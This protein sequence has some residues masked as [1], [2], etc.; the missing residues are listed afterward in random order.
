MSLW[1]TA[2]IFAQSVDTLFFQYILG[3]DCN[4]Y[5]ENQSAG[6]Y[7]GYYIIVAIYSVIVI[8]LSLKDL[9]ETASMQAVLTGYRFAAFFAMGATCLVASVYPNYFDSPDGKH[10]AAWSPFRSARASEIPTVE[11]SQFD[12]IFTISV[13]SLMVQYNM[14]DIITPMRTP[15]KRHES[16]VVAVLLG[17]MMAC[18]ALYIGLGLICSLTIGM[19]SYPLITL[20]WSHYT[21]YDGGWGLV[22]AGS[23]VYWWAQLIKLFIM[24]FP[25]INML[26]VFPLVAISLSENLRSS[27]PARFAK[28]HAA[29]DLKRYCRILACVPP[30]ILTCFN[31]Q[32]D[33][34]FK[35]A[36][37]V[38]FLIQL[39]IPCLLQWLSIRYCKRIWGEGSEETPFSFRLLSNQFSVFVVF[40]IGCGFAAYS[41]V[42]M[43]NEDAATA[44]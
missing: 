27:I 13:V 19:N 12:S 14:P 20:N 10:P 42:G 5:V 40:L 6:C 3:Q 9:T 35:V 41:V 1:V 23:D 44:S 33:L 26:S 16:G 34:I 37:F 4:I 15:Y 21:G 11:W 17:C 22:P 28:Q 30:L 36:G 39:I 43:V 24:L 8:F 32:I 7:T 25:V 29:E 2:A 18:V 31:G 38:A